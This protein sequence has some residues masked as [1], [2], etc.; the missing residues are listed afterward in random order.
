M[1]VSLGLMVSSDLP[2]LPVFAGQTMRGH[3]TTTSSVVAPPAPPP[4]P[5]PP[6]P[7]LTTAT[8][9]ATSTIVSGVPP[10]PPPPPPPSAAA[11]APPIASG[12][13][14]QKQQRLLSSAPSASSVSITG[15]EPPR[16]ALLDQIRQAGGKSS[17]RS[18]KLRQLAP[19]KKGP[20]LST[21][22]TNNNT[23]LSPTALAADSAAP[24]GDIMTALKA[25]LQLRR[26]GMEEKQ[27][28]LREYVHAYAH[29]YSLSF[30][31]Y[32]H[33]MFPPPHSFPPTNV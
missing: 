17:L 18:A 6:P 20:A 12:A 8:A 2:E 3:P 10:P 31:Y 15:A 32:L 9:L 21:T 33:D 16:N 4:P 26:K 13:T 19:A 11:T 28:L 5:P 7:P 1:I 25:A 23:P 24:K 27:A 29:L 30:D 14:A 22:T